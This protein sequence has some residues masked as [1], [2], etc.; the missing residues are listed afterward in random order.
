MAI[1]LNKATDCRVH[2]NLSWLKGDTKMGEFRLC[3]LPLFF[4]RDVD[5]V[6]NISSQSN[7]NGKVTIS[8]AD[9]GIGFDEKYKDKI[10]QIFQ[11]LHGKN[12]YEGTGIGLAICKNIVEHHNGTIAVSSTV[13][14]GTIFSVS[15]PK[16]QV[17]E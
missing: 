10:F 6:I 9:N 17:L 15:L 12:T 5:P 2:I 4:Y 7:G 11:R 3:Q 13:G 16:K 14:T 8:F 1:C